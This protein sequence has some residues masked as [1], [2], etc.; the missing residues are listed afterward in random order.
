MFILIL[1]HR[2]LALLFVIDPDIYVKYLHYS[3]EYITI[4]AF[5]TEINNSDS[6]RK[7]G[8]LVAW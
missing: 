1:N 4:V 2:H 6:I 7:S 5:S 3:F 8:S